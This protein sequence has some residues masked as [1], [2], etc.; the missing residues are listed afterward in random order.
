MF[1]HCNIQKEK[2]H[3][4]GKI[5]QIFKENNN[6]KFIHNIKTDHGS[7]G[8]PII[9]ENTLRVIGI[10]RGGDELKEINYGSFIGEIL[11]DIEIELNKGNINKNNYLNL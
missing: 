1:L 10:H 7:S 5:I 2:K 9:I 6:Y 8:C 11:N 3:A 4:N